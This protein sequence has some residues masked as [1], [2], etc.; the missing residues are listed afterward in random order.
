MYAAISAWEVTLSFGRRFPM[1]IAGP[2]GLFFLKKKGGRKGTRLQEKTPAFS[3]VL[4]GSATPLGPAIGTF[5]FLL[6][7][8]TS[9]CILHPH[10]PPFSLKRRCAEGSEFA[11]FSQPPG[12]SSTHPPP[13]DPPPDTGCL[14]HVSTHGGSTVPSSCNPNL[15]VFLLIFYIFF[16]VCFFGCLDDSSS[17]N[18][19][20]IDPFTSPYAFAPMDRPV[21]FFGFSVPFRSCIDICEFL[22]P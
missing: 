18:R 8:P 3:N 5:P 17:P 2:L 12:R 14:P 11:D 6:L 13:P 4:L 21:R 9:L 22:L 7:P 19:M 10:G 1:R 20:R 16:L 15:S